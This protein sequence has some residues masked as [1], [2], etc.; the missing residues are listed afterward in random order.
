[1]TIYRLALP[2]GLR[3]TPQTFNVTLTDAREAY[4]LAHRIARW[5]RRYRGM[6]GFTTLGATYGDRSTTY[7]LNAG[8]TVAAGDPPHEEG[9]A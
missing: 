4:R 6:L 9:A 8:G 1:M 2:T 3:P 7:H 5:Y